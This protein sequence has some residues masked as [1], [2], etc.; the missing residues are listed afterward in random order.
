MSTYSSSLDLNSNDYE[1][2]IRMRDFSEIDENNF[3]KQKPSICL[4]CFVIFITLS[5]VLFITYLAL[6]IFDQYNH[7]KI[8]NSTHIA[9]YTNNTNYQ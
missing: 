8:P 9:N 3:K 5:F 4:S 7:I 2:L 6:T 1:H